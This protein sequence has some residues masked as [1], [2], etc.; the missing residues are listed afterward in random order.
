MAG[1]KKHIIAAAAAIVFAGGVWV[2]DV[3]Y[4][5]MNT[6]AIDTC[7]QG[8][9]LSVNNKGL[10]STEVVCQKDTYIIEKAS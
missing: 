5:S 2:A 6:K 8:N 4:D 1:Y 9:V 7:G 3:I 10:F